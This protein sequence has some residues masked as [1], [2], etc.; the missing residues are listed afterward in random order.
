M[1]S[2]GG[3]ISHIQRSFKNLAILR[4]H[5]TTLFQFLQ[6]RLEAAD[7]SDLLEHYHIQ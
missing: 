1:S 2:V 7:I 4:T 5:I 6:F 3:G